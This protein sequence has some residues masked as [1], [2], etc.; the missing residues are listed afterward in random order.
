[1]TGTRDA[2]FVD[3]AHVNGEGRLT[4]ATE[5]AK[6]ILLDVQRGPDVE[7]ASP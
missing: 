5:I 2:M 3:V 4:K 6:A 1:M 7:P